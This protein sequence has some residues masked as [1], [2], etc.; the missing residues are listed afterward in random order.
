MRIKKYFRCASI[1]L[2]YPNKALYSTCSFKSLHCQQ[3]IVLR[4]PVN[5]EWMMRDTCTRSLYLSDCLNVVNI[6]GGSKDS[7]CDETRYMSE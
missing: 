5:T 4:N 3:L 7:R 2:S 1:L 6:L